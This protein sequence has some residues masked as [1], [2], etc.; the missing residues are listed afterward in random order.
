MVPVDLAVVA[1]AV[2]MDE[3]VVS[4][5]SSHMAYLRPYPFRCHDGST[6][7]WLRISDGS[8]AYNFRCVRC[9]PV[10]FLDS[11]HRIMMPFTPS[12]HPTDP[13]NI[14]PPLTT[15]HRPAQPPTWPPT[16]SHSPPSDAPPLPTGAHPPPPPPPRRHIW[17]QGQI[18]QHEAE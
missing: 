7:G 15:S 13:H 6:M 12:Q 1:L 16:T 2:E 3:C 14:P 18:Q 11:F 4:C 9:I 17:S 5:G 8:R 10:F